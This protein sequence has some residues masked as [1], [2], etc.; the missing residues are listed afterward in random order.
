MLDTSGMVSLEEATRRSI[1]TVFA[2]L[3]SEIG[4]EKLASTAKRIGIESELE[5][6][7]SLTLGA[8]A[9]TPIELASAYSS[10]ATNGKLAPPYLIE[11][12]EDSNGQLLYK[13]IIST[14]TSIPDPAAAAAVRKT[15][16][17]A[18]QFGTGTRA[19]LNDRPIAGKTGTHQGFRE[20][21]FIGF[22]PQYTSSVW[23]GFAEEQLPLTDV[24]I[25]GELIK[26]VSGGR[27]PA[28]IWKEFM[29]E[30]VKDLPIENWPEDPLDIERYYEIPKIEIPELV[31][32]NVLD[33]EEIA[34][35]GY[36]LPTIN[37]VDSEEAPGLVL[38]QNVLNCDR[39]GNGNQEETEASENSSNEDDDCIGVEMP[40]GTEVILEV[41]GKKFTGNLP[42]I[43]PCSL[44]SEEA[45]NL[46]KEFMRE[47]NVILFLKNSFELTELENCEGKVI[48]TNFP[49]G[50]SVST[51][52]SLIFIIGST[53]KD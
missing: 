13:H 18:A 23:I 9:V 38:K 16:E 48:G 46:V 43:P 19:V 24:Q 4:G 3:A 30:V 50:G 7:I 34:F 31:G 21:W 2:Q 5:P 40:E 10:F 20:A 12:I 29:E 15:L 14:R 1:N 25:N 8:G 41:S 45:E 11:K 53:N 36:I 44:T 37:L 51:G 52:D 49:Q 27:V 39:D 33:A 22:I 47:S 6:V 35:S 42:N 17:V 28:P 32:L 26:N